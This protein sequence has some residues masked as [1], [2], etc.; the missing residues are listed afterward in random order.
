MR[1]SSSV[2]LLLALLLLAGRAKGRAV[3]PQVATNLAK[4]RTLAKQAGFPDA[5]LDTAAAIAM[6]ESGAVATS[7]R[8]NPPREV[9]V[10]LWQVNTLVHKEFTEAELLNPEANA[11]AARAVFLKAGGSWSPWSSFTTRNPS[12]SYRRFMPT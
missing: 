12:L 11:R 5:E 3:T 8:R 2:L 10:G 1:R 9:S 6:A 4:L 7:V